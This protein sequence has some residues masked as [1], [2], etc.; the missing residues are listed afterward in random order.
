MSAPV[1]YWYDL[2]PDFVKVTQALLRMGACGIRDGD[3]YYRLTLSHRELRVWLACGPID[4]PH[5]VQQI[6]D[7]LQMSTWTVQRILDKLE[8]KH[9]VVVR[10]VIQ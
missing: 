6:A 9:Q 3:K 8:Q 1:V 10:G 7:S 4:N 5:S 2:E